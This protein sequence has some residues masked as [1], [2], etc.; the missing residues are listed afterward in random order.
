MKARIA[1][2]LLA[3]MPVRVCAQQVTQNSSDTIEGWIFQHLGDPATIHSSGDLGQVT[4]TIVSSITFQGCKVSETTRSATQGTWDA[5]MGSKLSDGTF[6]DTHVN[7]TL[8][9]TESVSTDLSNAQPEKIT[10]TEP[11]SNQTWQ[12]TQVFLNISLVRPVSV[13]SQRESVTNGGQV[14]TDPLTSQA[15]NLQISFSDYTLAQRQANAWR[16][17]I[18]ALR[19]QG[20]FGQLVLR[21]GK[22]D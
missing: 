13:W 16:D 12:T 3:V 5:P 4:S 15:S 6:V 9:D 11:K 22:K 14:R 7:L 17:L 19:R 2:L 21:G 10:I 18:T 20:G 1:I 8:H